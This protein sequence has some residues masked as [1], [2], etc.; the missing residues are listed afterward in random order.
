M[1]LCPLE[2]VTKWQ[3]MLCQLIEYVVTEGLPSA[4]PRPIFKEEE[5]LSRNAE[6]ALLAT[7]SACAWVTREMAQIQW[8]K[9]TT[10]AG[11]WLMKLRGQRTGINTFIYKCL[12][13][14]NLKG[15]ILCVDDFYKALR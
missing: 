5:R 6:T 3:K 13:H 11:E 12:N 9:E 15:C 14:L 2:E 4:E 10:A 7:H 8:G 1:Q